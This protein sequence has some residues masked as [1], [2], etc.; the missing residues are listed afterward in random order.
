MKNLLDT[1]WLNWAGVA[2]SLAM[3]F[4][5][6]RRLGGPDAEPHTA[7][8]TGAWIVMSVVWLGSAIYKTWNTPWRGGNLTK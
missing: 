4:L 6:I 1:P 2:V 8:V 7:F 3:T 5:Y